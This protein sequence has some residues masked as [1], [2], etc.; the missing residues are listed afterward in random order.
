MKMKN[1]KVIQKEHR[2]QIKKER[3]ELKRKRS[4]DNSLERESPKRS[5][6]PKIL[7]VCEGQNTEPSY[8]NQFKLKSADIETVGEGYNTVSLVNR[9]KIL[10]QKK[11]YDQVWCVFDKD[12]FKDED[13]NNA[14][15][16][17]ES[18]GFDMAYS[19]QAFEYWLI[20]HFNDHQG[21]SIHR[22]SYEGI[23]NKYLK[24]YELK[25]EGK[26]DKIISAGFFQLMLA[27]DKKDKKQRIDLATSRAEK[28]DLCKKEISPAK[29]ESI[30]TVYKLVQEIRK[31]L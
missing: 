4:C 25:Y 21:G 20:L 16:I 30:T 1:K 6:K 24:D 29:G 9:A 17:G 23:I 15:E 18:Y 14:I 2:E 5:E 7:I 22:K 19:N 31:Y 11:K 8:F 26:A 13:F 10:A 27:Y 28:I 3:L 12:D